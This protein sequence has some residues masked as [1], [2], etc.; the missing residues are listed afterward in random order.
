[1]I[2]GAKIEIPCPLCGAKLVLTKCRGR[3]LRAS[4]RSNMMAHIQR[5]HG[6]HNVREKSII[7][8][9]AWENVVV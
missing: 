6:I 1:M 2:E 5:V 9:V 8:D 3:S 7:A 4:G